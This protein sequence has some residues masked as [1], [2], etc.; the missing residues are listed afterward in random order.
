MTEHIP[1]GSRNSL[2]IQGRICKHWIIVALTRG[3]VGERAG[4]ER[5]TYVRLK[6][7]S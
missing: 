3:G 5:A 1:T 4:N 6:G 2:R 7:S